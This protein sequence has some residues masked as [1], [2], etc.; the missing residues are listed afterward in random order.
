[1]KR[2]LITL[3]LTLSVAAPAM[4][5]LALATS[6][7]ASGC[8][9]NSP[10]SPSRPMDDHST[11]CV[12]VVGGGPAGLMA[13]E[14]ISRTSTASVELFDAMPSFGRK[15]LMAGKGGM[16][17]THSE[18]LDAFLARYGA[19]RAALEPMIGAFGPEAL[20]AWMRSLGVDS[21]VGRSGRDFPTEKKA[22]PL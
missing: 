7:A 20:R 14:V 5:D 21:F 2:S 12:A 18:P 11:Q 22:A 15:F 3:A 13:A 10:P 6:K 1:M 8:R 19:R 9:R 4:A 16:N 17:I